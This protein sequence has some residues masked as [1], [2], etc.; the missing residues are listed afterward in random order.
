[1]NRIRRGRRLPSAVGFYLL[2]APARMFAE[3]RKGFGRIRLV[4]AVP[5]EFELAACVDQP[6]SGDG[7]I[8]VAGRFGERCLQSSRVSLPVL[9]L[10]SL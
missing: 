10:P 8:P 3:H 7:E 1:V 4:L 9:L 5:F 6:P 2:D